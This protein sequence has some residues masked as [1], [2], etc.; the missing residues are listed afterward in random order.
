[1]IADFHISTFDNLHSRFGTLPRG[2]TSNSDAP[3]RLGKMFGLDLDGMVS[4]F[5]AEEQALGFKVKGKDALL[6]LV[7]RNEGP[8]PDND[9]TEL[10]SVEPTIVLS[11]AES[12]SNW[13]HVRDRLMR[14]DKQGVIDVAEEILLSML[15][16]AGGAL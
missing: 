2:V 1:M 7:L 16:S 10:T 13:K 14:Y 15:T 11:Q 8:H 9:G 6:L 3:E 12:R 4:V 5:I